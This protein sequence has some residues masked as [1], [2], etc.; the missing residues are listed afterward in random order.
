MLGCSPLNVDAW[1]V[2]FCGDLGVCEK[3]FWLCHCMFVMLQDFGARFEVRLMGFLDF[4]SLLSANCTV[5]FGMAASYFDG[6][7]VEHEDFWRLR[8]ERQL[9]RQDTSFSF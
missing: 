9:H 7:K 3:L 8:M 5:V 6:S 4:G 2:C 1:V